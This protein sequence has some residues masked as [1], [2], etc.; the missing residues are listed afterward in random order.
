MKTF[1]LL[2]TIAATA[3]A[4]LAINAYAVPQTGTIGFSSIPGYNFALDTVADSFTIQSGANAQV[5]NRDGEFED[6]FSVGALTEFS[7]FNYDSGFISP[8]RIWSA[9]ANVGSNAG[10]LISFQ[11]ENILLV[12]DGT[13]TRSGV[14]TSFATIIGEGTIFSGA[15]SASSLFTMTINTTQSS[16]YTSFTWSSSQDAISIQ[17]ASS[18]PEPSAAAL[19]CLG[20]VGLALG[21]R[22]AARKS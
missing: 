22:R 17:E 10:E 12:Q 20:L 6:W 18:V 8:T 5:D 14:T 2:P 19:L 1:K 7:S 4:A 9:T 15:E 13:R 21:R 11:L 16:R 3:L